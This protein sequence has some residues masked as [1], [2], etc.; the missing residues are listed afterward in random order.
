M[1]NDSTSGV[2]NTPRVRSE[3]ADGVEATHPVYDMKSAMA[4]RV[5]NE[6]R[7]L[8]KRTPYER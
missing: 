8:S 2:K 1:R 5:R 4:P 3:F 6:L 7:S